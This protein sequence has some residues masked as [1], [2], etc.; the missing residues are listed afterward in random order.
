MSIAS[1]PTGDATTAVTASPQ[2]PAP[3]PLV[4]REAELD[5]LTSLLAHGR[6]SVVNV[7]GARGVGKSALVRAAL[8]R[9]SSGSTD[10]ARLDLTGET[11]AS[12]LTGPRPR[13]RWTWGSCRTCSTTTSRRS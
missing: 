6:T 9:A 8:E 10:V 1:E 13:T 12:A 11:S 5:T 7:T 4:G 2:D 3:E